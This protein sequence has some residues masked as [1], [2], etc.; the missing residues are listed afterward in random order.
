MKITLTVTGDSGNTSSATINTKSVDPLSDARS[1]LTSLIRLVQKSERF[2][3]YE[4]MLTKVPQKIPVIKLVRELTHID[5]K[6]AKEIVDASMP[7]VEVQQALVG[8]IDQEVLGD[9]TRGL[10]ELGVTY[11]VTAG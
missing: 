10:D 2:V 3:T 4:I 9:W 5:L 1:T 8:G 6:A 7:D 11:L